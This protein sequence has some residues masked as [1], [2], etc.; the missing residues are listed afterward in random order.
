MELSDDEIYRRAVA[1]IEQWGANA[2]LEAMRN[3]RECADR[4][5]QDAS[6]WLRIAAVIAEIQD[7]EPS[8]PLHSRAAD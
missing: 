3:Y 1:L 7:A 5:S 6:I 8:G 2:W 4:S